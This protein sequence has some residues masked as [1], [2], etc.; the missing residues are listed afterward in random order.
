MKYLNKKNFLVYM[1]I[2]GFKQKLQ[3]YIDED[4]ADFLSLE[5]N[6]YKDLCI[7]FE[8]IKKREYFQETKTQIFSDLTLW[9]TPEQDNTYINLQRIMDHID[10]ITLIQKQLLDSDIIIRGCITY[11]D[12]YVDDNIVYGEALVNA[13]ECESKEVCYPVVVVDQSIMDYLNN[14]NQSEEHREI[15]SVIKRYLTDFNHKFH[16]VDYLGLHLYLIPMLFEQMVKKHK[17]LIEQSIPKYKDNPNIL[18]KYLWLKEYHN[19][20]LR[21]HSPEYDKYL[22][23]DK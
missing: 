19:H 3:E 8:K 22:V 20:A 7:D 10:S 9:L 12:M 2:L 18:N 17:E 16:Y 23:L 14:V 11:G 4:M 1:D 6:V 5:F 21:K 15:V 13:H